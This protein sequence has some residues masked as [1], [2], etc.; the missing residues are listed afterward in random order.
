MHSILTGPALLTSDSAN[1][2]YRVR[3]PYNMTL[4][5]G[6]V[7]TVCTRAGLVPVCYKSE[8]YKVEGC[9]L[10]QGGNSLAVQD[11]SLILCGNNSYSNCQELWG[12]FVEMNNYAG[13]VWGVMSGTTVAG[14][15]YTKYGQ[16]YALCGHLK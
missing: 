7:T 3:I 15:S 9:L 8:R 14:K 16:Y 5:E 6:S 4:V 12:V 2:Y 13:G 1:T 11:I 10:T